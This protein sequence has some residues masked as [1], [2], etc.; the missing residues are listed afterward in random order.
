MIFT[1][2]ILF[3]FVKFYEV[4][5]KILAIDLKKYIFAHYAHEQN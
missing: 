3:S 1:R 4:T 5:I 2:M